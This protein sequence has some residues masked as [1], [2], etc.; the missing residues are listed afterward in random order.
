METAPVTREDLMARLESLGIAVSLTEH[1]PLHTVEDSKALRGQISGGHTKNLFL[2]DK[3]GALFLLVVEE[4]AVIDLK[5]IDKTIG[6]ARLSFGKPELLAEKLGVTPGSVTA[7]AVI[8]DP[9][10]EVSVIFDD[11]LMR[12]EI[13][14]CHPL[15]NDA[16]VSIRRDDLLTFMRACGHTP[17]LLPL[18]RETAQIKTGDMK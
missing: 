16:T 10:A 12:H 14:N 15:S 2:K 18:H 4:D 9:E 7:F 3:K 5:S 13:I 11:R 6:S 8:N 1:P 17:T